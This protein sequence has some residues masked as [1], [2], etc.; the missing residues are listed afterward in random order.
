MTVGRETTWHI[1]RRL[2]AAPFVSMLKSSGARA[3]E[4]HK[5]PSALFEG[6]T[7]RSVSHAGA[8]RHKDEIFSFLQLQIKAVT[9][10]TQKFDLLASCISRIAT[11]FYL[12]L[13]QTQFVVFGSTGERK[14]G[15]LTAGH[16]EDGHLAGHE[17]YSVSAAVDILRDQ[18]E[19]TRRSRLIADTGDGEFAWCCLIHEFVNVI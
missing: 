17:N 6:L 19:R 8:H 2:P 3:V 15:R 18:I 16:A 5:Q 10:Y 9:G 13:D 11:K 4:N 7:Q 14:V 1:G 12:S